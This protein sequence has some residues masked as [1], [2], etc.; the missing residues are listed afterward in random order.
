MTTVALEWD[1]QTA[2]VAIAQRRPTGTV[3]LRAVSLDVDG[4]LEKLATTLRE[5]LPEIRW[6]KS[7]LVVALGEEQITLRLLKLPPV[8]ESELPDMVRLLA[9]REF[10][11]DD[12]AVDFVPLT[13]DA[14]TPRTVL[15]V[16][17]RQKTLKAI[18]RLAEKL[19]TTVSR[20][21]PRACAAASLGVKLDATLATDASLIVAPTET[22]ADLVVLADGLPALIRTSRQD[23][24]PDAHASD[25]P[26]LA[27]AASSDPVPGEGA[28]ASEGAA[29]EIRRTLSS[30]SLQLGRTVS[31]VATLGEQRHA[32]GAD[33]LPLA[34]QAQTK[35][36]LPAS[37]SPAIALAAGVA[38]AAIDEAEKVKPAIDL[39]NP[40]QAVVDRTP[41]RRKLIYAG[42]AAA[43]VALVVGQ[44]YWSLA[45]LQ[46]ETQDITSS[47]RAIDKSLEKFEPDLNQTAAIENWL[48]TDV[49][50]LDEIELLSRQ[51]RPQPL[52]AKDFPAS[53]DVMLT[54]LLAGASSGRNAGGGT[55]RFDALAPNA[56]APTAL[57][58]RL[59]GPDREVSQGTLDQ[60]G[61]GSYRWRFKPSIKIMPTSAEAAQ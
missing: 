14:T 6:S 34:E 41:L 46:S 18:D 33:L 8:P 11:G 27:G 39:L 60:S 48:S 49:N 35:W 16:R 10:G 29:V 9:E 15:A 50:W 17:V 44:A 2:R 45:S 52:S 31:R 40:R 32:P 61:Q 4:D 38:G 24:S 59:R 12:G 55:L 56:A 36:R 43:A 30:A 21:V 19:D 7:P 5:A 23:H 54:Q 1:Q 22:G 20:I 57:E 13:G 42:A 58:Q 25:T 26:A 53:E 47:I 51:V 37:D 3:L 28:T